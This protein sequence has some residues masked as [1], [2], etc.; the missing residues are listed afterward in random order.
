MD[1]R[2]DKAM[3]IRQAG[4]TKIRSLLTAQQLQ[5]LDAIQKE[6]QRQQGATAPPQQ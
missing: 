3:Q 2:Q 4:A 6:R 1:Q 5:K